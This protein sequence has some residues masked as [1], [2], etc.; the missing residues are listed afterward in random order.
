MG[1]CP[2]CGKGRLFQGFLTL[3]PQCRICGLDTEFADSGDGPAVFAMTIVGFI[4]V[5]AALG[6][7][8]AYAPPIW[9]HMLLWVPLTIGLGLAILRPLK[10][11]LI[12]QQYARR[13]EEGRL[14]SHRPDTP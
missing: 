7:E 2:R 14:A 5:G 9:L 10:G 4:V 1:R 6:L 3:A 11:L 12:A 13:A 8:L